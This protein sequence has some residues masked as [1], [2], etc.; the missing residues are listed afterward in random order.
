[1]EIWCRDDLACDASPQWE[2]ALE[3]CLARVPS[4]WNLP[5]WKVQAWHSLAVGAP[6]PPHFPYQAPIQGAYPTHWTG[7]AQFVADLKIQRHCAG[8]ASVKTYLSREGVVLLSVP[9]KSRFLP[10]SLAILFL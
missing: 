8:R 3:N 9:G 6:A 1:M 10:E 5:T 2:N 7:L 4:A